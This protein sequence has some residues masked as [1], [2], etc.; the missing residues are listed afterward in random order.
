V[1]AN[2]DNHLP[3]APTNAP[4]ILVVPRLPIAE[5]V[6]APGVAD[7]EG[8]AEPMDM[9]PRDMDAGSALMALGL[10]KEFAD[11]LNLKNGAKVGSP[12]YG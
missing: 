6:T 1:Q 4:G 3:Q 11:T 2:G 10:G 12:F 9:D 7:V 8:T 5:P